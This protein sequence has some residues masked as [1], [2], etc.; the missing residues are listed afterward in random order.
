MNA[1]PNATDAAQAFVD[2]HFP[3]CLTAF[4]GGSVVRGDATKTSDLDILIITDHPDAPYRESRIE[5]GWPIEVFVHTIESAA[6]YFASDAQ[7]R[8]PTLPMLCTE[9]VILRDQN[10]QAAMLR[11]EAQAIL[12][13]GPEPLSEVEIS[14]YRYFLTDL[15]DDLEGS[16]RSEETLFIAGE[17]AALAAEVLLASNQRWIGKGKWIPRAIRRYDPFAAQQ[18]V[19]ALQ[20][21]YSGGSPDALISFVDGIL[22]PLGGRLFDGYKLP[23]RK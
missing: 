18:L 13:A 6:R 12:D 14:N 1:R 21:V 15:L 19:T 7:R 5:Q 8:R 23:G 4:L 10:G 17:L 2:T 22:K 20:A 3:D 16:T 11:N 9:G